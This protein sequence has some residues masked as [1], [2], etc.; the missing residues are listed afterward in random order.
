MMGLRLWAVMPARYR[1]PSIAGART[2][3]R[4]RRADR[5]AACGPR[6]GRRVVSVCGGSGGAALVSWTVAMPV[7]ETRAEHLEVPAS[8]PTTG[9]GRETIDPA[10]LKM[11]SEPGFRPG[12]ADGNRTRTVSLEV[13]VGSAGLIG[14]RS[15]IGSVQADSLVGRPAWYGSYRIVT[16][17]FPNKIPNKIF[18][19]AHGDPPSGIDVPARP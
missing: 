4:W 11:L 19:A 13:P 2:Q 10:W 16:G 6:R 7:K 14:D 8:G 15:E 17:L 1:A 12:A 9:N 3:L 5:V 18:G